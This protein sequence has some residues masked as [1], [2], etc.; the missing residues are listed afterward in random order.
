MNILQLHCS[1]IAPH[2]KYRMRRLGGI[3]ETTESSSELFGLYRQL[4]AYAWVATLSLG[5]LPMLHRSRSGSQADHKHVC[6]KAL[7][8]LEAF[9]CS[10]TQM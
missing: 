6:M 1:G 3:R 8:D 7:A 5:F 9:G 4:A 2:K 10:R